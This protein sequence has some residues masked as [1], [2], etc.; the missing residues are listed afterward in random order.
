MKRWD[1]LDKIEAV[2][3]HSCD[4]PAGIH[5]QLTKEMVQSRLH[6]IEQ[7]QKLFAGFFSI[8][9]LC[10]KIPV[11]FPFIIVMYF[12]GMII[13]GPLVY[14]LVARNRYLFHANSGCKDNSCFR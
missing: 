13:V 5:A 2:D 8:R 14:A 6:L 7:G 1:W 11:L 4:D 12:P 3:Y 9:R 10:L